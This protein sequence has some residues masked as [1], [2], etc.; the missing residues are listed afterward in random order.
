[1]DWNYGLVLSGDTHPFVRWRWGGVGIL[2]KQLHNH[3]SRSA[4][5]SS[6]HIPLLEEKAMIMSAVDIY[7]KIPVLEY[8]QITGYIYIGT[9]Q[10]CHPHFENL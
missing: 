8:S 1:M 3:S 9:N 4:L 6:G 7:S 2:A 10:C 5:D